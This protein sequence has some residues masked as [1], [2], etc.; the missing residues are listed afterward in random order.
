MGF[1][2]VYMI[3]PKIH[4]FPSTESPGLEN[5]IDVLGCSISLDL[6]VLFVNVVSIIPTTLSGAFDDIADDNSLTAVLLIPLH[7]ADPKGV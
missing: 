6:D 5:F 7:S 2:N 1:A 3:T 4:M